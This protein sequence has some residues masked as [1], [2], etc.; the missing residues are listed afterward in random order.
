MSFLSSPHL[1]EKRVTHMAVSIQYPELIESLSRWGISSVPVPS[2]KGL[3]AP[4]S[5]H[6]DMLLH[7]LGGNELLCAHNDQ[8][9]R[10]QLRAL[11][12]VLIEPAY[13]LEKNY[14]KDIGLNALSLGYHAFGKSSALDPVLINYWKEQGKKLIP[15][16]QGYTKCS[17]CV[18]DESHVI[19]SDR[20]IAK[21]MEQVGISVLPVET[22]GILLEGYSCGF[23]GGCAGKLAPDEICF[24]GCLSLHPQGQEIKKFL[25]SCGV[26]W[27]ELSHRPLTD[28]GSL[29]PLRQD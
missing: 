24:T 10:G 2:Y 25:K 15:V 6:A 19:C 9:L 16:R 4:V 18:I 8:G 7:P 29:I 1:P 20:G 27:R 13:Q 22:K 21:A 26:F 11:G 17:C 23:I 14:P 28:V 3:D 5:S 12:F